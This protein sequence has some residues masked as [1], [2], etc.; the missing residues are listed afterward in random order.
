MKS[1]KL[2]GQNA[3][4][5]DDVFVFE[6]LNFLKF[7]KPNLSEKLNCKQNWDLRVLSFFKFLNKEMEAIYH[8]TDLIVKLNIAFKM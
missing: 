6:T 1:T 7:Y 3:W 5:L 8:N 2:K 4:N